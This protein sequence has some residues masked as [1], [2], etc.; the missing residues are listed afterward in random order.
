MKSSLLLILFIIISFLLIRCYTNNIKTAGS[1]QG[2]V[3]NPVILYADPFDSRIITVSSETGERMTLFGE[4]ES[5]GTVSID[6]MVIINAN[7]DSCIM[8][9]NN[10]KPS[11]YYA[12]DGTTFTF[13]WISDNSVA[14]T[15]VDPT[16]EWSL[17]TNI[18]NENNVSN[19]SKLSIKQKKSNRI[20][21][22]YSVQFTDIPERQIDLD[23]SVSIHTRASNAEDES[24]ILNVTRCN[25]PD[26]NSTLSG[27]IGVRMYSSNKFLAD[28]RPTFLGNGRYLVSVPGSEVPSI[29][30]QKLVDI[31]N[32]VLDNYCNSIDFLTGGGVVEGST[33]CSSI[34]LALLATPALEVAPV[35]LAACESFTLF[36][37]FGCALHT[38]IQNC[39]VTKAFVEYISAEQL[40]DYRLVPYQLGMPYDCVG[41]SIRVTPGSLSTMSMTLD[42]GGST[43]F[44]KFFLSPSHPREDQDYLIIADIVCIIPG[45]S[46]TISIIGSDGYSDSETFDFPSGTF[47]QRCILEVPGAEE[48]VKDECNVIVNCPDGTQVVRHA[49]LIFGH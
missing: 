5:D 25:M 27:T 32:D 39:D 33:I 44:D 12:P 20:N 40:F 13:D 19:N 9:L 37:S 30:P 4:K 43:S 17:H 2:G 18:D 38:I 34:T 3:N 47:N 35:F 45:S 29:N 10:G 15:A 24:C 6:K 28:L 7:N 22:N 41:T 8:L 11:V 23:E 49:Y 48:N 21:R 14:L 46:V 36:S 1:G 26:D 31:V 42:L 16:G